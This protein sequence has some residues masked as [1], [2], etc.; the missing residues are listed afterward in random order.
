MLSELDDKQDIWAAKKQTAGMQ[1]VRLAANV[2]QP[3]HN[4]LAQVPS[5]K[6]RNVL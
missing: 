2:L 5:Q 3:A 6:A 1:Y 4:L